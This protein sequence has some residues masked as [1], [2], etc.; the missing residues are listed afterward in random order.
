MK[1]T[2]R[3]F[4]KIIMQVSL[5]YGIAA[6]GGYSYATEIEPNWLDLERINIPI[7]GLK[8]ALQGIR[9]AALSD[10]HLYPLTQIEVVEKAVNLINEIYP[11]LVVLLGDYV[12]E[13][14]E[15][16]FELVPVLANIKSK[17]GIYA[18]LGNHDLWTDA[19]TVQK[20]FRQ[21]G[22]PMLINSGK[23]LEIN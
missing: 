5:G 10:I 15:V 3:E 1:L 17:Y 21:V 6:L 18:I 19:E 14:A 7:Q 4:L 9:I 13:S 11:D 12:L 16:I 22:I 2:R 20:G 23:V 8:P